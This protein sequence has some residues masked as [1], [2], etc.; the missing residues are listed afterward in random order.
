MADRPEPH[1]PLHDQPF[2]EL[3][4]QACQAVI[5]SDG[6]WIAV[7]SVMHQY[8]RVAVYRAADLS[9]AHLLTF[10][11]EAESIAFH[12]TLPL[13]A[14]GLDNYDEYC[15]EGGLTLLEADTGHR[16]DFADPAWGIEPVR[17]LDDRTLELTYFALDHGV[18][19]LMA[20][21]T[22]VRDDWRGL[23]PDALDLT[24]LDRTALDP[25]DP[26]TYDDI[27]PAQPLLRALAERAGRSYDARGG[28]R[29]VAGVGD[30]RVLATRRDAAVECWAADGSELWSVPA[31]SAIGGARIEVAADERT[32]RVAVAGPDTRTRTDFLLVDTADGT[33]LDRRSVP[34]S[35]A[36]SARTDGV[37]AIRDTYDRSFG[38][39]PPTPPNTR[40]FAA[41]GKRIGSVHVPDR[42]DLVPLDARRCP[43]LLYGRRGRDVVALASD[44]AAETVL[45]TVDAPLGRVVYV[46]DAAGTALLHGQSELVRRA[47]PS[48]EVQWS[49]PLEAAVSAL[50]THAGVLHALCA[51]NSLVSLDAADGTVLHRRTLPPY[52]PLSLH[53]APDGT[54]LVGTTAGQILRFPAA[55]VPTGTAGRDAVGAASDFR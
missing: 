52:Q 7:S 16:V 4:G 26:R 13:L 9:C 34:F 28:V 18:G 23:A 3:L 24:A 50:D 14:V 19:S 40:I 41:D 11:M 44:G 51:D 1:T 8:S 37:W 43:E 25:E 38:S 39:E 42:Y 20:R 30:G 54:I 6:Q 31:P 33:V 46:S 12:P 2:P 17:W 22:V 10:T 45:F 48:G 5:S 29:A 35:A 21:A 53:A 15:R 27:P 32:V 47:F 36:M 55:H 49:R